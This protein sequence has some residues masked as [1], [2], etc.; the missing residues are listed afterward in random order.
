[1]GMNTPCSSIA[2]AGIAVG[3]FSIPSGRNEWAEVVLGTAGHQHWHFISFKRIESI[4]S[5]NNMVVWL[6]VC[7]IMNSDT[8]SVRLT[9][10][11]T[12]Y[13]GPQPAFSEPTNLTA[14]KLYEVFTVESVCICRV[15][16]SIA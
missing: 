11:R 5:K 1:M 13:I 10:E 2:H 14:S 3:R 16:T 12:P 4:A 8:Y 7:S 6:H 9:V 15:I